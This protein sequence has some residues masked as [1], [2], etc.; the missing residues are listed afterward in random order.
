MNLLILG[1]R[2]QTG[3]GRVTN[4]LGQRFLAAGA[5][6][7]ILAVNWRG[8][9]GEA[10]GLIQRGATG[11]ELAAHL[12][13]FDADPLNALSISAGRHGDLFGHNML[14]PALL[15]DL[16]NGWKPDRILV[17]ADP[18][19]LGERLLRSDGLGEVPTYNYVPIEGTGLPPCW[20]VLWER[21]TPVAMSEFGRTQ[22]ERLLGR[23]VAAIPHGVSDAF[24]PVSPERPGD[25]IT[26]KDGAK[27]ALGLTGHL[28]LFRADRF[29]PR[30]NYPA[31]FRSVAP[32]LAEHPE[33]MLF[34][35][36]APLDEGGAMA[37]LVSRL[38]G[39]FETNGTWR[40]PQ[41]RITGGHDTFRG[42][43]DVALN[44]LYNAADIYVSPTQAEGFGLTLA[45]AASAAVPVVTTDFAAGPEVVGP[46][47]L[48][49]PPSALFTNVY[50][51]EWA[52]ASEPLFTDAVR[53]LADH[54]TS[55]TEI[56]AAG[57]RHIARY[58][59]D[60]AAADFLEL[61]T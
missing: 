59:W 11:A 60:R 13:A 7:R 58:S 48:L 36:C 50:G 33:A 57:A 26:S 49:V 32:V 23:P 10:L 14:A 39:A 31:L 37:S 38:P 52:A 47:A 45:E 42:L 18:Q 12:D 51:F 17:V 46:G 35:H 15:G 34:L 27:A 53:Q 22:L 16:W 24:Y 30:K 56:G 29:V 20:D 28:V 2:A 8:R 1:D 43:P 54:P 25:G 40:H 5:S 55:R 3:F 9:D 19:A 41:V 61:M 44:V 21:V 4:E 6:V